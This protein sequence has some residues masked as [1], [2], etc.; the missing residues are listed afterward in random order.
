MRR[1]IYLV[2]SLALLVAACGGA[3]DDPSTT[4]VVQTGTGNDGSTTP[5]TTAAT[6]GTETTATPETTTA[7]EATAAPEETTTT[8]EPPTGSDDDRSVLIA[9]IAKTG[10]FTSAR[11][12]G[13]ITVVGAEGQPSG[14]TATMGF[15]GEYDTRIPASIALIDF[16]DL[17]P[18][19]PGAD[20]L[21]PEMAASIGEFEVRAIG[22]KAY[23]RIGLFSSLGIPT[24]WVSLTTDE[25]SEIASGFGANTA[26][27]MGTL[28]VFY[29]A[30]AD[31]EVIGQEQVRGVDTTHFRISADVEKL[32]ALADPEQADE[33]RNTSGF[34]A[35]GVLPI[36]M[37][38]GDDGFVRRFSYKVD[39][40]SS[41]DAGFE[42]L[43]MVWEIFDYG[44]PITVIAPPAN[45]VTDGDL[46]VSLATGL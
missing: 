14:T 34:P 18:G 38:I 37:W 4:V 46:L 44:E 23:M 27:P 24:P 32:L 16:S 22:D 29:H 30:D 17:A 45:Q 6:G 33:L 26:D 25:A 2:V 35:D 43:E 13:W 20:S 3:A 39:G 36:D 40:G 31:V 12:E 10:Q 8:T 19:M 7:P 1:I 15:T 21:G 5:T 11:T 41:P 9:A 28:P 42:S